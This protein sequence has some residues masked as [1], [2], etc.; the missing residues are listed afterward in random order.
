MLRGWALCLT[1]QMAKMV[2]SQQ[3]TEV[4]EHLVTSAN[5]PIPVLSTALNYAEDL[6]A[7]DGKSQ[8]DSLG[9]LRRYDANRLL[10]GIREN[11][12]D[13]TAPGANTALAAQYP[14]RSLIW[15]NPTNGAPMGI[16]LTIGL[17]P[18]PLDANFTAAGGL[19]DQYWW[20]YTVSADGHIYTGYK[21]KILRYSPNGS[22]GLNPAPTVVFT[23]TLDDLTAR[24]IDVA[25][26]PGWRWGRLRVTGTGAN[27]VLLAGATSR[28]RGNWL[29]T[30]TDG[31]TF[32]AGSFLDIGG[33][34]STP[35]SPDPAM[36][37][38][39]AVYA[40]IYPGNSNGTDS[41]YSRY[42][43]VPPFTENFTRDSA[44][45][46]PRDPFTY[47]EK[48]R[49]DF[50][51]DVDANQ[52]TNLLAVYS[53]PSWNSRAVGISTPRP[54]WLA[55]TTPDG[56]FL[57]SH[58]IDVTEDAELL[59]TPKASIFQGTVGAVSLNV[60]P[61]GE[62]EVLWS[63]MIYGY[64]RYLV[65]P[66][67]PA[68]VIPEGGLPPGPF[69]GNSV[70]AANWVA[71]GGPTFDA[72]VSIGQDGQGP[73][74]WSN[75]RY[76]RGD[77]AVRLSP[78]DPTAAQDNFGVL[79]EFPGEGT[80]AIPSEQ[81]WRP[82]PE[83]GVIIPS[84][85]ANGP[86]DWSDG[87]GGFYP[88]IAASVGGSSGFGYSL[89]DGSFGK[90]NTDIQTGKA[91]DQSAN[92][93]PEGN[94]NFATTWF[95]YH[96]GWT[97]AAVDNPNEDGTTRFA[98]T[99][100]HS[101]NLSA[102]NI[103]WPD[104][105]AGSAL[106]SIPNVRTADGM[107]FATSTQGGSDVK[108]VS[109]A[110]RADGTGW[111]VS[112]HRAAEPDPAV[113]A[114]GSAQFQ[115]VYIPYAASKLTGGHAK[116]D[117]ALAHSAG[118]LTLNRTGAGTYS[119]AIPGK[120]GTRGALLLQNANFVAGS[121]STADNTFLSYQYDETAGAFVIQ[122]RRT[123]AGGQF[124]LTDTSFYFAWIDFQDPLKPAVST[125]PVT[126]PT[127]AISRSGATATITWPEHG[128]GF[129]LETASRLGAQANWSAV[130]VT[131]QGALATSYPVPAA[132]SPQYFRLRK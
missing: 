60:L 45:T 101:A 105:P 38:D 116:A 73:I 36:P 46:A 62:T 56:R 1:L 95:P 68:L 63:G 130:G 76:N 126:Q 15:I 67:G 48:Y 28:A 115:F 53:A 90:A 108:V 70:S 35:V 42:V 59:P 88:V 78:L 104:G 100:S 129:T 55:L 89:T 96:Q 131:G 82:T 30:T 83:V 117:G 58:L 7:G 123:A 71:Q 23:L 17:R 27:T 2:H 19:P 98:G 18:V 13:E 51:A 32:T 20:N 110:P 94:F 47:L 39:K 92:P 107:L 127:L 122:A 37:D 84:V 106:V 40:G 86:I 61:T 50:I 54:G 77:F 93:S 25:L 16:A 5:P 112:A 120:T 24:G 72:T 79:Q 12:I 64:G 21:N 85:R 57:S 9:A 125:G 75:S 8:M 114:S 74:P 6:D 132:N 113:V 11:G 81:A 41:S 124:P 34:T 66:Y 33:A 121:S 87:L 14:D 29:L 52:A 10:L 65:T 118:N 109:A 91:G 3:L 80:A 44:F 111:V 49:A 26:W 4:W 43:A 97:G 128:H 69:P 22:G 31:N 99:E 119:L 103:T 102:E